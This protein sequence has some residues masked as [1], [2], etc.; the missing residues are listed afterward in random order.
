M[1][2][3]MQKTPYTL[4]FKDRVEVLEHKLNRRV[5][6]YHWVIIGM[7]WALAN[8]FVARQ[9]VNTITAEVPSL[10]NTQ[11]DS[12]TVRKIAQLIEGEAERIRKVLDDAN[13]GQQEPD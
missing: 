7:G 6:P 13:S 4:A 11:V 9:M 5:E 3:R 1:L 2:E 12:G 10:K 8:P